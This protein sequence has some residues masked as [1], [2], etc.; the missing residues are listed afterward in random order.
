MA[1]C[2]TLMQSRLQSQE[3]HARDICLCTYN[4]WGVEHGFWYRARQIGL[5]SYLRETTENTSVV[6]MLQSICQR[7]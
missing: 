4:A 6:N 5:L 2:V 7:I 3:L 1:V